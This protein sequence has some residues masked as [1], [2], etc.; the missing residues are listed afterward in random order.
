MLNFIN[1]F[2]IYVYSI[3]QL[4][5]FWDAISTKIDTLNVI[6]LTKYKKG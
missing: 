1:W 6:I 2:L 4:I 3:M 5:L